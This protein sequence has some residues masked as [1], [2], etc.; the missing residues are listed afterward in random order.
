MRKRIL[1]NQSFMQP[2]LTI[3]IPTYNRCEKLKLQLERVIPHLSESVVCHVYDNAS[4][5]DTFRV[6]TEYANSF[7]KIHTCHTNL[8][9][10]RNFLRCFEECLTPWLWV[11]SDDDSFD[12]ESLERI[13]RMLSETECDFIHTSSHLAKYDTDRVAQSLDDLFE[14]TNLSALF[15]ISAGFYRMEKL[16]ERLHVFASSI[17]TWVPQTAMLLSALELGKKPILLSS[18]ELINSA[19]ETPRF[20]TLDFIIR[21]ASSPEFLSRE[22]SKQKL[23]HQILHEHF[24]WALL[25]GLRE[26]TSPDAIVRWK[27]IYRQCKAFL[28][29]YQPQGIFW[30]SLSR[31]F[32][33]GTKRKSLTALLQ[34]FHLSIF[35]NVPN[36]A[37][38]LF[39]RRFPHPTWLRHEILGKTASYKITK[40]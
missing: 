16:K 10:G 4:T 7:L 38:G 29:C 21:L 27:R 22:N 11:L 20:S 32:T 31:L 18:V 23:A 37:F 19:P 15:F 26:V 5:D 34:M 2:L 12:K 28:Y 8:G 3:A 1:S 39:L 6:A 36:F 35:N 40:Y 24:Q 30:H 17:S 9:I 13:I 14:K 33:Y 25:L